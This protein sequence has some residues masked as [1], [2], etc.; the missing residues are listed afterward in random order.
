MRV[1][2]VPGAVPPLP[3]SAGYTKLEVIASDA[4]ACGG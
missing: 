1:D 4:D 2:I 3:R